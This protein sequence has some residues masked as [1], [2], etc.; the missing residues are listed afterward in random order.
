VGEEK[1]PPSVLQHIFTTHLPN[2]ACEEFFG[3][4]EGDDTHDDV[5]AEHDDGRHFV[6][7]IVARV[8]G[9]NA[10][11]AIRQTFAAYPT[12]TLDELPPSGTAVRL[13]DTAIR[14]DDQNEG[15]PVMIDVGNRE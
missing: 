10:C 6:R 4:L 11:Q 13:D 3:S 14:I 9:N 1:A 12:D 5:F 7:A 2:G 8:A 15:C